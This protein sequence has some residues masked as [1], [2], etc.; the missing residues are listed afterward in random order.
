MSIR[1]VPADGLT[2][3]LSLRG[4]RNLEISLFRDTFYFNKLK[5]RNRKREKGKSVHFQKAL[6]KANSEINTCSLQSQAEVEFTC[7]IRWTQR[8]TQPSL[9]KQTLKQL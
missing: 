4:D 9:E 1:S 6:F 2:M 5:F 8:V 3:C 7:P